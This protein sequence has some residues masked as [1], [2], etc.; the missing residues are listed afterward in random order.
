MPFFD[1]IAQ[2]DKQERISGVVDAA[3]ADTALAT[4]TDQGFLV[5]SLK[6]RV[7]KRGIATEIKFFNRWTTQGV[8]VEDP[9]LKN[10][11]N[12][13]SKLMLKMQ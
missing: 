13:D 9:G 7:E 12:L 4:L 1:Y 2:N 11:I 10:A 3:T 5:L 6:I 8:K